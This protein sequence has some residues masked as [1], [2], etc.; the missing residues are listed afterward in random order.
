M[1]QPRVPVPQ[2][3]SRVFTEVA[4][5]SRIIWHVLTHIGDPAAG[6]NF[7]RVV[8]LYPY[9]RV[10]DRTKAYLD[11]AFE[12]LL[13]WA[14][15][16]A[17]F[18]FHPDQ[19]TNFALRPTYTLARAALESAAQA[20]WVLATRDPMECVRRHL[21][22]M[23]WDLAEHAKSKSDLVEKQRIRETDAQL[24]ARVANVFTEV[25][26]QAPGG[27]YLQVMQAACTEEG[28][29]HLEAVDVERIWRTM[30]GAAHGKYWPTL[31][32]QSI[33]PGEEYEQG[34][35]RTLTLPDPASMVEAM[36]TA[37]KMAQI[38]VLRHA[39]YSGA[40]I[41]ALLAQARL[42]L[43]S[44]MTLRD[45]ADPAAVAWFSRPDDAP[46]E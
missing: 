10:P 26:I 36:Q 19:V 8:D 25:Q 33:F 46:L 31:D 22:L 18:K 3:H 16:V 41:G 14:D 43:G 34:Q 37:L 6:S 23:R 42:W 39:D 12:H 1:T 20:V 30:S 17:P 4:Q 40:N 28:D 32:L 9:E 38:G 15:Y 5:G 44:Q 7:A 21:C 45:D 29:L 24:V 35:F 2:E 13:L 11:A 27:G